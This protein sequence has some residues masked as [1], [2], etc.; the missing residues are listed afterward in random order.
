M[1]Q[2]AKELLGKAGIQQDHILI[3]EAPG[4][5][6]L[7]LMARA[8]ITE[9]GVNGIVAIGILLEG[10]TSHAAVVAQAV[11]TG[12]MNLQLEYGIPC[13]Q[14]VLHVLSLEQASDRVEAGAEGARAVLQALEELRKLNK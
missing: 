1:V 8:L 13:A 12:L 14:E 4:S 10:E 2:S 3:V 7:P 11:A 5:F 6:E 9:K